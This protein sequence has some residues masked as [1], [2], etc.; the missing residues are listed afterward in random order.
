MVGEEAGQCV[1]ASCDRADAVVA[2]FFAIK[3]RFSYVVK[4]P[5]GLTDY[6]VMTEP[7]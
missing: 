1:V 2:A 5:S 4:M 3:S 7:L 6:D